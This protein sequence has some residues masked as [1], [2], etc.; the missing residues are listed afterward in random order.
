[1]KIERLLLLLLLTTVAAPPAVWAQQ[2]PSSTPPS[3]AQQP[4]G[5]Q[6][7]RAEKDDTSRGRTLIQFTLKGTFLKAPRTAAPNRPAILV[8]CVPDRHDGMEGRFSDAQVL[9]GSPVKIDY[10]EP[11]QLTTG[12][13]YNLDVDVQF[14]V[15]EKKV[16]AMQWA[17][18]ADKNSAAIPKD[19]V[20]EMLRAHTV[21]MTVHEKDAGEVE[22][23]FDM[24]DPAQ[25]EKGCDISPR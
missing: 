17:A 16:Q 5:P 12:N 11:P 23:Q 14:H 25:V 7:R 24:P 10:V 21:R 22:M 18:G 4:S 6:W 19:A 9:V 1:M 3:P 13:S 8:S 20:K 2:K 15:D